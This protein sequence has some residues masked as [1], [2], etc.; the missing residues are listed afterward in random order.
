MSVAIPVHEFL[1]AVLEDDT[2]TTT[3]FLQQSII[4]KLSN[5]DYLHVQLV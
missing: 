3:G 1:Q 4:A 5:T 2:A